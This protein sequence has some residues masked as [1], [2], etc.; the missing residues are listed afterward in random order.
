MVRINALVFLFIIEFLLILFCLNIFLFLRHRK[1]TIKKI[2]SDGEIQKLRNDIER[3]KNKIV[4]LLSWKDMFNELDKRFQLVRTINV[5]LKDSLTVLIPE[6][7]R[8][9]ELKKIIADFEYT[10]KE[11][12]MCVGVL[13]QET[14]SLNQKMKYFEDEIDG[15]SERLQRSVNKKEFDRI[16]AER[17]ELAGKLRKLEKEPNNRAKAYK[18]L[19]DKYTS[20]EKEYNALYRDIKGERESG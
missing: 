14:E 16:L 12:D 8:S 13:K 9:E 18:D 17:D 7:E 3:Q 4:E 20:L 19:Q 11:L 1:Q 15:L 10:N 6:D 5:K 2:I